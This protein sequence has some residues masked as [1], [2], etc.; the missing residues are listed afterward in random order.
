M[1]IKKSNRI[2]VYK[3][4]YHTCKKATCFNH[5][6]AGYRTL[7]KKT[8]KYKKKEKIQVSLKSDETNN[9]FT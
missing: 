3:Q 6:Q 4:L 9:C 2:I 7:N 1:Y 8:I 5:H